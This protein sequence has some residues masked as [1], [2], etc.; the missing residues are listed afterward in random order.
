KRFRQI[1]VVLGGHSHASVGGK[2]LG[3]GWFIQA[4]SRGR[5]LGRVRLTIDTEK[6]RVIR[7]ESVLIPVTPDIPADPE[8]RAVVADWLARTEAIG[9][10]VLTTPTVDVTPAGLPG[11]DCV[12][13]EIICRAFAAAAPG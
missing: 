1:D 6:H 4:G 7:K 5:N 8:A 9:D 12:M 13:S 11:E 3:G 2:I 10:T